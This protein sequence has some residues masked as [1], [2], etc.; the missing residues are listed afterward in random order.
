[1]TPEYAIDRS[2][3]W[4]IQAHLFDCDAAFLP[5]LS[6]R[7]NLQEYAQKLASHAVRVEAWF[8]ENLIGLVAVYCNDPTRETAFISNV[9]VHAQHRGKGIARILM[10]LAIKHTR[11]LGFKSIELD[12]NEQATVALSLYQGLGF[13]FISSSRNPIRLRLMLPHELRLI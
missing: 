9:S 13:Y 1:M 12:V 3:V 4:D 10:Q 7:L 11:E 5:P 8:G 2:T 6:S